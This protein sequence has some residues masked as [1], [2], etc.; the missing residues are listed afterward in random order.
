M[1]DPSPPDIEI[2]LA[3]QRGKGLETRI[4]VL[5]H[6]SENHL[7]ED[8][9]LD[10]ALPPLVAIV[11]VPARRL[12]GGVVR[13]HLRLLRD[14]SGERRRRIQGVRKMGDHR[15]VWPRLMKEIIS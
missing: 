13:N 3:H 6:P 11:L 5:D 4:V 10:H 8:L 12:L 1:T 9:D 15:T 14:T 7:V 2:V